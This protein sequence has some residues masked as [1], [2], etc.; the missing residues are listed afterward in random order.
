MFL[1]V[2]KF[3]PQ[4]SDQLRIAALRAPQRTPKTNGGSLLSY[5]LVEKKLEIWSTF[6]L[7]IRLI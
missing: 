2:L 3:S 6:D 4:S 1:F 7:P 5:P